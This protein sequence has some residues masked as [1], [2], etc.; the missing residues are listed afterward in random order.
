M[1]DIL[2]WIEVGKLSAERDDNLVNYFFD[3]GV[4]QS[5]INTPSSFLILGRKGA[6]KTALFRYL[7]NNPRQYLKDNEVL[8]S[9]SFEDYNWRVHSLLSNEYA[10]ESLAYK[11]SWKFVIL[12]EV[13]K[14]YL[15][16]LEENRLTIPKPLKNAKVALE[17]IFDTPFPSIS[18]LVGRKLL[19]L[20]K[21]SLPKAGLDISDGDLN[22]LE[23]NGGEVNFESASSDP[24]LRDKLC[25]NIDHLI[26]YFESCL[27]SS[28]PMHAK[29][30][31][32]FDR[33]D[34]A[35]DDISVDV[36]R[37]VIAG[38][39][40]AADAI[41]PKYNGNIRPLIFLRE[42]IFEVLSLNDSNKLREDCGALLHWSRDTLMKMLLQRINYYGANVNKEPVHDV[43]ELFDRPE[44]RQRAKPFNYLMKR[45]MMRPRDMICLLTKTISSMRD[46]K[47]DPFSD[48]D[49]VGD[50]LEVEY[51]Y[52]AEPSYSE[53][54]KQEINDEWAVQR[55]EIKILMSAIQ[56]HSST[57]FT[58]NEL[59]AEL[60]KIDATYNTE[61]IN[62]QIRFMF[63][64]SLI[65]FKVGQSTIWRYKCFY[66]SQ[67]FI[68]SDEY[69]IHDGLIRVLNLK[70]PRDKSDA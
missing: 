32:C 54:L 15:K 47:N 21:I 14:A 12:V 6:G 67:G 34:E 17:K 7:T 26:D 28:Q 23:L 64:I 4:L 48:N 35:W 18:V 66:P 37:R 50:K 9:L 51:I 44:M 31:V 52:Q 33:I 36:S 3:N 68:D 8:V 70:E 65:G 5:V 20:G 25:N 62:E 29:V 63:D 40:T 53:W 49:L 55:P 61:L 19:G 24:D 11:Q 69:K 16:Y 60:Q 38:L 45:S 46:D 1:S 22:S 58:K 59:V 2:S 39:V 27:R 30:F 41:T 57:I 13:I 42:D 10:A 43:D 56:N